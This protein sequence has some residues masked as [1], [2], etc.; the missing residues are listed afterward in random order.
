MGFKKRISLVL[1]ALCIFILGGCSLYNN[2][3]ESSINSD[4][5]AAGSLNNWTLDNSVLNGAALV[6]NKSVYQQDDPNDVSTF[7]ITVYPTVDADGNTVTLK[8]FDLHSARNHDYNPTLNVLVQEGDTAGPKAGGLG[9]GDTVANAIMRVRGNSSRGAALK[10]YK[11]ILNEAAGAWKNQTALNLNKHYGDPT[12]IA[13]KFS[14]DMISRMDDIA[15]LRTQFVHLYIK[16]LSSDAQT[17]AFVDYGLY[18]NTE[19]PNKTYLKSHGLD[20]NGSLYKAE[21]FEFQVYPAL[22]NT[23]DPEYN[24]AEFEKILEIREGGDHSKLIRMLQDINDY[25]QDFDTVFNK[26]FNKD[27]YLTWMAVNFLVGNEDTTAHNFMLYNPSNS[28]TWY[29]LPW[30]YDGTF[31]FGSEKSAYFAPDALYGVPHYWSI[32]LH[33]RFLQEQKNVDALVAKIEEVHQVLNKTA[34]QELVDKYKT[35]LRQFMTKDPDLSA[36]ELPPDQ[37]EPYLDGF[38]GFIEDN[39]RRV[40]ASIQYPMPVFLADPE[41]LPNGNVRFAWE[42]SYDLQGDLITYDF[43]VAKDPDMKE[44]VYSVTDYIGTEVKVEN[45]PAGAYYI[46]VMIRDSEGHVQYGADN[47]QLFENGTKLIGSYWGVRQADVG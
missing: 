36:S 7:Y 22:K 33:K 18:T 26:Y 27:N 20:E 10:S 14:M 1:T 11:V 19:Q 44:I 41:R 25:S 30:D 38:G 13:Q 21:N 29:F 2:V 17:A 23:D 45:L 34:S 5:E 16:D 40:I 24:E 9:Y 4:G 8:D 12:K 43:T 35:V 6:E 37:I 15:S 42:P 3:E 32:V 31:R 39:Y 47:Y 28:L 46:K